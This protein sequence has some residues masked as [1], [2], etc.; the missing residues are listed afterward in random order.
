MAEARRRRYL[1]CSETTATKTNS[2]ESGQ[3]REILTHAASGIY[4]FLTPLPLVHVRSPAARSFPNAKETAAAAMSFETSPDTLC[5]A[6]LSS[7]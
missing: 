5:E 4:S 3:K 6:S 7:V 1:L 2:L